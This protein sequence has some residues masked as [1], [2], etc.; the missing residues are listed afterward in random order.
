MYFFCFLPLSLFP[1]IYLS[2]FLPSF[3]AVL[4]TYLSLSPSPS[5]SHSFPLFLPITLCI[6]IY[7][8]ICIYTQIFCIFHIKSGTSKLF[9]CSLVYHLNRKIKYI[10]KKVKMRSL[11]FK[12]VKIL[13]TKKQKLFK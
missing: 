10:E 2:V 5:F 9:T 6:F 13:N 3:L 8:H 7:M 11:F 1:Y 4:Y 12:M